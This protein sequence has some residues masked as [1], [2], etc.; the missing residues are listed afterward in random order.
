M[1][2]LALAILKQC[3]NRESEYILSEIVAIWQGN[4]KPFRYLKWKV[5]HDKGKISQYFGFCIAITEKYSSATQIS[6]FK[7]F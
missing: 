2:P 1:W 5:S 7:V 4:E 3:P 6:S